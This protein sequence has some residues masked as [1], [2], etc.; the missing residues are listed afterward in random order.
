MNQPLKVIVVGAGNR[1]MI[2]AGYAQLHPEEMQ[3]VGVAELSPIR[4]KKAQ[5]IYNIPDDM[6]FES[7]EELCKKGK[8]ADAVINGTMDADHVPTTKLLLRAGYDVLL[9]KP[10]CINEEEM[11]DLADVAKQTGRKVMICHVLRY[12]PFYRTIK[13]IILSGELGDVY[14]IQ[15]TEHVSYHH[16]V[17]AY[18]RGKWASP[19]EC[20]A[21]MLLAKS[22]HD[23]DLLMWLMGDAKPV[24]ISSF[25]SDFTFT[26]DKKPKEAGTK[27]LLD[28]PL[29]KECIHSARRNYMVENDRWAAYVWASLET[30]DADV[31]NG[32]NPDMETRVASLTGDNPFGKC[33][34][35]CKR[36][37]NV[38]HQ[39][40][41]VNFE[42]GQTATFN[43]IGGT[44]R[45][46]RGVHIIGTKGELVGVFNDS[47]FTIRKPMPE[48]EEGFT[49]Q[50]IDLEITGDM[51]GEHGGH[52]GGDLRVPED[53][54]K[55]VRGEEPSV[56]CTALDQSVL[57][58][59]AVFRA[60]K[61]RKEN[62]VVSM[63][64]DDK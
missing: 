8:L 51:T 12:A 2:Y 38:D 64:R 29:D 19:I 39:S 61:A 4:R 25:G 24:A 53:F 16:T 31:V 58:H 50:V 15:L 11:F 5:E 62:R 10:F 60:E 32:L 21:P 44:A 42:N 48:T 59:L 7:A 52:G 35:E 43:M 45:G 26:A 30:E 46:E 49:E 20:L 63:E 17:A 6:C 47:K 33:V 56:S 55:Y 14:N 54:V 23:L 18:V 57:G 34:W 1:A 27:C 3:I 36:D 41:L 22:C 28:C 40:V 13:D 9:E 37:G